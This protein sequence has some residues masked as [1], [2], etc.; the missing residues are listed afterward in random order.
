MITVEGV[1][2]IRRVIAL[3][4]QVHRRRGPKPNQDADFDRPTPW[5]QGETLL[6]PSARRTCDSCV[7]RG[8]VG[9]KPMALCPST[10]I[11]TV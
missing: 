7:M 1:L 9:L 10:V 11:I 3:A 8:A 5:L 6:A 2:M 4:T